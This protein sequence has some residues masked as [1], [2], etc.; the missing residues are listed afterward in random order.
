MVREATR[1]Q[2]EGKSFAGLVFAH[3]TQTT[4]GDCIHDLEII[5]KAGEPADLAD[6][7]IYL[8]L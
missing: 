4:F 3:P 2:S 7:I 6:T 5:G 8:P 1:R